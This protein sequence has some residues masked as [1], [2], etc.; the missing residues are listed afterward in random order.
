LRARRAS[1]LADT[2]LAFEMPPPKRYARRVSGFQ[3]APSSGFRRSLTRALSA[4]L[5]LVLLA[6]CAPSGA[7]AVS[8]SAAGAS[9]SAA[10]ASTSA[11]GASKPST[12]ATTTGSPIGEPFKGAAE[13]TPQTT[14]TTTA[15]TTATTTGETNSTEPTNSKSTVL[16]G[17]AAA[18]LLLVGIAFVIARDARRV[19]PAV[20]GED[21]LAEAR[22]ARDRAVMLQK[23]RARAKAARQQRKRNAARAKR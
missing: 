12:A 6:A 22:S 11:A 23:R 14:A 7:S 5:V 3:P 8:T 13:T 18:I 15:S 17:L 1:A 9:T 21:E 20:E 10:G 4:T 2:A 16:I 19:A